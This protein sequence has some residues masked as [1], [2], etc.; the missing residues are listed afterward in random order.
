[1]TRDELLAVPRE[2]L[3]R[4]VDY[5]AG[6]AASFEEDRA[7]LTGEGQHD[8]YAA[9]LLTFAEDGR[10]LALIVAAALELTWSP[11]VRAG[12]TAL[13]WLKQCPWGGE[14][15]CLGCGNLAFEEG[16]PGQ[17]HKAGCEVARVLAMAADLRLHPNDRR[18][19]VLMPI[20]DRDGLVATM[21][22]EKASRERWDELAEEQ[23][24][25]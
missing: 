20:A 5:Y 10:M 3:R 19:M 21:K 24:R 15:E 12:L 25:D 7:Y 9:K 23:S 1:M 13:A 2:Q 11:E 16:M 14:R 6:K 4:M 8:K 17:P 22:G 18:E